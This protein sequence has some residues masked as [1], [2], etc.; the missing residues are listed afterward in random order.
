MARFLENHDEPR[1]AATFPSGVHEAAAVV[2]FLAPGLRFF[3][4]GQLD[5]RLTRISAHLGR[6]PH[7]PENSAG[8]EFYQ[9]LLDVFRR[10]VLRHGQW[11]LLECV[12]AWDGNGSS[13]GFPA[14]AWQDASGERLLVS[15][16]YAA[17]RSQSYVR[18]PFPDLAS[19]QW[20]LQDLLG[21]ARYDR[22]GTDLQSRGL[23][24]DI[25]PWHC[26]AFVMTK[27]L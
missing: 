18:L 19:R 25:A 11:Q 5:G 7:E 12:P 13:D 26:H 9:R 23:Y 1:A 16:N 27:V 21:E 10:P 22:D 6:G 14:C 2:T 24:L 20:R 4:H 3:H 17:H 15:V 8:R